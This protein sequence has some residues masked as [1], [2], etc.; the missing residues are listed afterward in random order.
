LLILSLTVA[1][2]LRYLGVLLMGSLLIVPP[3]AA[4]IVA[5][6]LRQ[7]LTLSAAIAVISTLSGSWL[8]GQFG[9]ETGPMIVLVAASV[10]L[11]CLA[12]APLVPL[13]HFKDLPEARTGKSD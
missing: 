3:A 10:F 4:R 6:G 1:L 8:A 13:A 2:G 5:R 7:M 9:R 11:V 12:V